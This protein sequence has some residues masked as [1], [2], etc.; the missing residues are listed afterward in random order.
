MTEIME[1]LRQNNPSLPPL[2]L[3]GGEVGLIIL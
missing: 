1:R 3:R 2:S